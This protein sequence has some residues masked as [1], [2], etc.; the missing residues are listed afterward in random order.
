MHK[1]YS[2]IALCCVAAA[3]AGCG[4]SGDSASNPNGHGPPNNN[5]FRADLAALCSQVNS[6]AKGAS[7]AK[8]VALLN[9]VLPQ[10][11][12]LN[13]RGSLQP[14]YAQFLATIE[15]EAAALRTKNASALKA[16]KQQRAVLAKELG[17]PS[18]A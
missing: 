9:K 17:V 4:S 12:Q 2:A 13:A 8:D 5:V 1:R 16:A 10:L 6:A 7:P 3:L 14:K 11:K 18:C 15:A